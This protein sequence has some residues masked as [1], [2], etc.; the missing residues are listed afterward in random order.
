LFTLDDFVKKIIALGVNEELAYSLIDE[1]KKVR[2]T[3]FL[4]D[5]ERCIA[6]AA[7][8]S[9]LVLALIKSQKTSQSVNLDKIYF[10]QFYKEIRSY[11][12][13]SAEDEVLTLVI[14]DVT[15]SIYTLRS[16]KDVVHFKTIDPNFVDSIYCVTACDWI[17][18]QLALLF[19][20]MDE[21]EAHELTNSV[22]RKKI[23]LIEEFEDGTLQV[24]QRNLKKRDEI[25][26]ILYH[27][28]PKRVR[29]SELQKA[30]RTNV[31]VYLRELEDEKI[32]HKTREGSKLTQLG[33]KYVE[34]QLLPIIFNDVVLRH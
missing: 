6:H 18:V 25:L 15:R 27:Y 7:R 33:I 23:P 9:E 29:N 4:N 31:S 22:L 11:P 13:S 19:L 5:Y 10:E 30:V 12:K 8:F 3:Q 16:K 32:I 21:K 2:M 1:Y 24:L 14:P 26:L 17:L 28:Y 34:E 20:K